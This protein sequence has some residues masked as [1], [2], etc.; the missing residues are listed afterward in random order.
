MYYK[1]QQIYNGKKNAIN[2]IN[3]WL[4]LYKKNVLHVKIVKYIYVVAFYKKSNMH[5][6]KYSL[7][8]SS[9]EQLSKILPL[10]M[11]NLL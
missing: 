6:G 7:K 4:Y 8:N 2:N 9:S 11:H 10:N 5:S 3:L 1:T